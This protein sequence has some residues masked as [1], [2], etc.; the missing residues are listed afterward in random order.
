M[1]RRPLTLLLPILAAA[2]IAGCGGNDDSSTAQGGQSAAPA[3]HDGPQHVHG[4]GLNPADGALYV[5]THRGLWRAASGKS[6]AKR[7]G[8]V[9]TT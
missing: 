8:D 6:T 5:A 3:A 2:L 9:H 4:L 1:P 7:V